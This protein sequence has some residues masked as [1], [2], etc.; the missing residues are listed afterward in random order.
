MLTRRLRAYSL[1]ET[2]DC[3][4]RARSASACVSPKARPQDADRRDVLHKRIADE[5][6]RFGRRI[7]PA[8]TLRGDELR[9][10]HENVP[11]HRIAAE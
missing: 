9:S 6:D 8:A 3:S 10:V 4:A 2:P 7:A 11:E 1:V 5:D